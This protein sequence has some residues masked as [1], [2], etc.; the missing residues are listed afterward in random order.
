M[1]GKTDSNLNDVLS[2]RRAKTSTM[3]CRKIINDVLSVRI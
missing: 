2:A 1:E 3:Y